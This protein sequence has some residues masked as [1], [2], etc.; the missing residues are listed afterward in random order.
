VPRPTR[1]GRLGLYGMHE[2]A[3]LLGGSISIETDPGRG[4]RVVARIPLAEE[5]KAGNG[6]SGGNEAVE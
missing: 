5:D 2:R 3:T 4:T 6:S 1:E